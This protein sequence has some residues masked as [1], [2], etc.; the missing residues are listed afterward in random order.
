MIVLDFPFTA[1]ASAWVS[2]LCHIC[3]FACNLNIWNDCC[4]FS[5]RMTNDIV[6]WKDTRSLH[7]CPWPIHRIYKYTGIWTGTGANV[8][9]EARKPDNSTSH[10]SHHGLN[11]VTDRQRQLVHNWTLS[12]LSCKVTSTVEWRNTR[13]SSDTQNVQTVLYVKFPTTRLRLMPLFPFESLP[14]Y[15][16]ARII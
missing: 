4:I 12:N 10:L 15:N 6:W 8:S 2:E 1:L 11:G 9:V 7:L 16:P 14:V 5:K 13:N 3:L